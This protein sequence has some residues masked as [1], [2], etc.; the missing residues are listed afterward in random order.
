MKCRGCG[1]T[2][3]E[4]QEMYSDTDNRKYFFETMYGEPCCQ[5]DECVW[6]YIMEHEP[7]TEEE[8]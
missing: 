1:T 8:E 7:L 4:A 5:N 6:D 3:K 2:F